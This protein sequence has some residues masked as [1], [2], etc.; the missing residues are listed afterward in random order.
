MSKLQPGKTM[1][2]RVVRETPLGYMLT[3]GREEVL[4]HRNEATATLAE[5]EEV[6]VFIYLDREGRLTSTMTL[7][8]IEAGTYQWVK[9]VG[10]EP[11][12]GVFVDI[13]ISKDLLVEKNDLP[14]LESLWPAEG[15]LLYCTIKATKRGL[16]YGKPATEDVMQGISK[17]APKS[18]FNKDINAT[19]YRVLRVGTSFITDEGYL[20]FVHE[21]ERR[22]E[23]RLGERVKVRVIHVKEDGT[24]NL[25]MLPRK[26]EGMGED[27]DKIYEYLQSRSGAMPYW[28]KSFPE[29]IRDRFNM[30]KAAFKR[31]LGKLMKENKITQEEGWTYIK[32]EEEGDSRG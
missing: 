17:E 13:G 29:D 32:K 8:V 7:P 1:V 26:Q 18:L 2:L 30:S 9:V 16:L 21:T 24:L 11:G 25:S 27:A 22:E 15:D 19:V 23:P 14:A 12:L 5:E 3:D 6:K 20:G 31:A 28:D 4:L 10:T